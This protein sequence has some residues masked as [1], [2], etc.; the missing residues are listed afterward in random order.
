MVVKPNG[1]KQRP[2]MKHDET[3]IVTQDALLR[4]IAARGPRENT[5]VHES[6]VIEGKTW[7]S[8][9]VMTVVSLSRACSA[10][11]KEVVA[12]REREN[13]EADDNTDSQG[14]SG[15]IGL[16]KDDIGSNSSSVRGAL[17]S[18]ADV[19]AGKSKLASLAP[20][21][22]DVRGRHQ[23]NHRH[24][25]RVHTFASRGRTILEHLDLDTESQS[26]V[27]CLVGILTVVL[28][29]RCIC[30]EKNNVIGG[31]GTRFWGCPGRNERQSICVAL[32]LPARLLVIERHEAIGWGVDFVPTVTTAISDQTNVLEPGLITPEFQAVGRW[33]G[34][35]KIPKPPLC[36]NLRYTYKLIYGALIPVKLV[37]Y[38]SPLSYQLCCTPSD[39][40]WRRPSPV[41]LVDRVG[42][43]YITVSS[44]PPCHG[45]CRRTQLLSQRVQAT[46]TIQFSQALERSTLEALVKYDDQGIRY[47]TCNEIHKNPRE[48]IT[49]LWT[50]RGG[51]LSTVV[52]HNSTAGTT[53]RR[54][55]KR[56]FGPSTNGNF[57]VAIRAKNEMQTLHMR[58]GGKGAG[59]MGGIPGDDTG[60]F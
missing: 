21:L 44:W 45:T 4:V 14:T 29:A 10:P 28:H 3:S 2:S 38:T 54:H 22:H 24:R 58:E 33:P 52:K 20:S 59:Y 16:R 1:H 56:D 7:S 36:G 40:L 34:C 5:H 46:L 37:W 51:V 25:E 19:G 50:A 15:E 39:F 60:P 23:L 13:S 17:I 9:R 12:K 6:G 26:V 35:H 11:R 43:D 48:K 49:A 47:T 41:G 42:T 30:S 55:G 53:E 57:V 8:E 32:N 27:N 18:N 31:Q